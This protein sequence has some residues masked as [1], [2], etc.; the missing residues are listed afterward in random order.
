MK[1]LALGATLAFAAF[2]AATTVQVEAREVSL[3]QAAAE[4]G[5]T[6]AYLGPEDAVSLGKPGVTILIRP[7][8]RLFDVN[9][10]TE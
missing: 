1:R 10:R 2:A 9:D 4:L 8:Q 7:G 6:Y 3:Q 5:F